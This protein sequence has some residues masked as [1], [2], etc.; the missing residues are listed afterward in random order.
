[1]GSGWRRCPGLPVGGV[2]EVETGGLGCDSSRPSAALEARTGQVA[3]ADAVSS[4]HDPYHGS[5]CLSAFA[6][7]S[8]PAEPDPRVAAILAPWISPR[9]RRGQP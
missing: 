7:G 4:S 8:G 2:L 9:I 6:G 3:W 5:P 1:M